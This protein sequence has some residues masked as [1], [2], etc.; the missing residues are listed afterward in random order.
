[1]FKIFKCLLCKL[2]VLDYKYF[3]SDS[4]WKCNFLVQITADLLSELISL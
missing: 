3:Y 2:Y 1:M 4:K